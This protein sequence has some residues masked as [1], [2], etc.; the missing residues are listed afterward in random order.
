MDLVPTWSEFFRHPIG[1][2]GKWLQILKLHVAHESEETAKRRQRRIEETQKTKAYRV[3]HGLEPAEGQGIGL[4]KV[5]AAI[6]GQTS[7]G[8]QELTV[9]EQ[10]SGTE[11]V[12][13]EGN[14]RRYK[15]WF[16]IWG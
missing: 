13:F 8:G 4:G 11:Y 2:I 5:G 14:K 9:A 6:T 15:K 10:G 12:D 1:S 3:A 16:G 7:G